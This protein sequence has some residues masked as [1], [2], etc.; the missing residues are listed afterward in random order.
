[1]LEALSAALLI[2]ATLLIAGG[3]SFLVYRLISGPVTGGE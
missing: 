3:S 1:M 2:A